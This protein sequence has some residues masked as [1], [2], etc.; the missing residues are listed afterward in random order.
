MIPQT[1]DARSV[2]VPSDVKPPHFD[3]ESLPENAKPDIPLT[4]SWESPNPNSPISIPVFL[5]RPLSDP[6]SRDL[7]L[8]F[9]EDTSF[10]DQLNAMAESADCILYVITKNGRIL[11]VGRKLTLR[12]I[13]TT[14]AIRRPDGLLL[15]GL[16]LKDGWCLEV[17]VL[18][19]N[20]AAD[21]WVQ[22]QKRELKR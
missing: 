14:A 10:G 21:E 2:P 11:K 7:I 16:E 17:F 12:E 9:H 22:N 3:Y 5:L 13:M 15:D 1:W 19:K 4:G 6:P 18:P 8:A 20:G